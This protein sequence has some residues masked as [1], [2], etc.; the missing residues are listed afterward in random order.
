MSQ[1]LFDPTFGVQPQ[2]IAVAHLLSLYESSIFEDCEAET[3]ERVEFRTYPYY[4]G[5]ERGIALV[6][7]DW[8]GS[9]GLIINFGEN[10]NSDSIFVAHLE[11]KTPYNCPSV[12]EGTITEEAY[13]SRKYFA[14][15]EGYKAADYI[16]GL[17]KKYVETV[18]KQITTKKQKS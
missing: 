13:Q 3:I 17:V 11:A 8:I 15:N 4:N 2:A 7:T 5:R 16:T 12:A 10:R 18:N 6:I 14:Y 9:K 1:R